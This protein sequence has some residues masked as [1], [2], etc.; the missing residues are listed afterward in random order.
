MINF[1]PDLSAK[2]NEENFLDAIKT[3][4]TGEVTYAVRDTVIDDKQ[5]HQGDFMGIGDDGIV[6]VG[7]EWMM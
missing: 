5:I 7:K 3:V 2:E 6:S 4:Q 1:I